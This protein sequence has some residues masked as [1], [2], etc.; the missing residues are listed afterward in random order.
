MVRER[1]GP[2]IAKV[3]NPQP[4][5]TR[6][7]ALTRADDTLWAWMFDQADIISEGA[8]DREGTVHV[9][10]GTTSIILPVGD[11]LRTATLDP[12]L[13]LRAVR[14]AHREAQVR[15]AGSLGPVH[16]DIVVRS[17]DHEVRIDVELDALVDVVVHE[18]ASKL[19]HT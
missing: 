7:V 8:T 15:A 6:A 3:R 17:T 12:H 16:M 9:Y 2:G 5:A 11:S 1:H 14:I 19:G 10:R 18:G 13:R 4:L